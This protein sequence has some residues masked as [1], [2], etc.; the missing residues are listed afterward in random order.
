MLKYIDPILVGSRHVLRVHARKLGMKDIRFPAATQESGENNLAV[1]DV[2]GGKKQY[3]DFGSVTREGG[4]LSMQAVSK[5][6]D[7]AMEGSVDAVVT[8]PISK[9]AIA[10]AEYEARGHTEYIAERIGS[11]QHAMML[12]AENLRVGLVTGHIPIWDVPKAMSADAIIDKVQVISDSLIQDFGITRPKIA[13]LGLN[14]HAGDGGVLGIEEQ[15][16]ILP[17]I[18][19]CREKNMLA[20]GPFPADGFFGSRTYQQ[21]DAVLAMYHD[22]GLIPFKTLTFGSG[23]NYTAGLSMVRTSPDHGTAFDIAGRGI[24]SPDSL[25][26]A[27][28]LAADI[29]RQRGSQE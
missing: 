20:F 8:G 4:E 19:Q 12:V 2:A 15:D 11:D 16:I 3:V 22:Q 7:M 9:E 25:R 21:Y 23:V 5:A 28:F 18:E 29:V 6:I 24:A 13:V 14:P 1:V 27:L 17:A 10:L 26:S